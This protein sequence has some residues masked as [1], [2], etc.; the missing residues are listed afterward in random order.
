LSTTTRTATN[1]RR[2]YKEQVMS[3]IPACRSA[4]F[5]LA[6]GLA[7]SGAA[8]ADDSSMSR[9][10]G[11]SY[12]YFNNL[13]YHA[14]SFNTARAP[15]GEQPAGVAKA[16]VKDKAVERESANRSATSARSISHGVGGA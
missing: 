5:A 1:I 11:D 10:T 4:A 3:R 8:L 6:L 14:G 7:A 12:A 15:Q 9:L 16:T 2:L 13:D